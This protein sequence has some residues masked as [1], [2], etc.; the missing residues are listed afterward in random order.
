MRLFT[1]CLISVLLGSEIL[2]SA[3][4]TS[5]AVNFTD[6]GFN[7]FETV[8]GNW[9][10]TPTGFREYS[11]LPEDDSVVVSNRF[12]FGP[13]AVLTAT[14]LPADTIGLIWIDFGRS[15]NGNCLRLVHE[16]GSITKVSLFRV[17]NGKTVLLASVDNTDIPVDAGGNGRTLRFRVSSSSDAVQVQ[18]NNSNLFCIRCSEIPVGGIALGVRGRKVEFKTISVKR[19]PKLSL[20]MT[21]KEIKNKEFQVKHHALRHNF[22]R[23][24][25][26]IF[27]LRFINR[28]DSD[29]FVD[30]VYAVFPDGTKI[31]LP[32]KIAKSGKEASWDIPL[33]GAFWDGK[34][35]ITVEGN[36]GGEM[37]QTEYDVYFAERPGKDSYV[38]ATWE[39]SVE[40][41]FLDFLSKNGIN[42]STMVFTPY[43][44]FRENRKVVAKLNDTAV[45]NNMV[46][47]A[48]FPLI[49]VLS[50][51]QLKNAIILP[52]G[53]PGRLLNCNLPASYEYAGERGRALGKFLKDYPAFRTVLLSSEA[54]NFMSISFSPGDRERYSK[55]FGGPVPS[56]KAESADIDGTSGTILR[57]PADIKKS[58]SPIVPTDN[59]WYRWLTFLWKR[60]FGDNLL[61]AHLSNE[62][63]KENPDLETIH[64]PFRD[65]P[66]FDRNIGLD[67]YGTWF[68]PTPDAGESFMAIESILAAIKGGGGTQKM[69]FGASLWLYSGVF[70]PAR[71]QQAGVQPENIYMETLH[72]GLASRPDKFEVFTLRDLHPDTHLE[73]RQDTLL[74]KIRDFSKNMA[75]PLWPALRQFQRE[76]RPVSLLLSSASQIFG[77]QCW[78]GYGFSE[79]NALLNILWKANLPSNVVFEDTLR[80]DS[81]WEKCKILVLGTTTH[82]PEDVFRKISDFAGK[83]GKVLAC[84]PF[85]K[86]IPG[87]EPLDMN[88]DFAT[89]ASYHFLRGKGKYTALKA[90]EQRLAYANKL[91]ERYR[92]YI[93]TF[94][95]S[96]SREV[97]LRTLQD[98]HSKF[99]FALNDKRTEGDHM[100]K[101]FH[102]VL[103][104]GMEQSVSIQLDAPEGVVYEF[105]AGKELPAVRENKK[106]RLDL[107]FA[108]SEGKVLL[109]YPERI[110]TLSVS[111]PVVGKAGEFTTAAITLTDSR[112]E[113][114]RGMVP[115]RICWTDPS[116]RTGIEYNAVRNGKKKISKR[117]AKGRAGMWSVLVTELASGKTAKADFCQK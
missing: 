104:E 114:F 69:Q 73:Y 16:S 117:M 74:T 28:C 70:C 88:F 83:G 52:N 47:K 95:D 9:Q 66:V 22:Y 78:G 41:S 93:K 36:A 109:C 35:K 20:I 19:Y 61:N 38:F 1:L 107:K 44:D 106:L 111:S 87:A 86:L 3:E 4:H 42:G 80:K 71:S 23:D 112:G 8:S 115:V 6:G 68:Y 108:P 89:K 12:R 75:E 60:G 84:A 79:E 113:P 76:E 53:K 31:S 54:E 25:K 45:R 65:Y 48:S 62:I 26:P 37:L 33:D 90:Q 27:E 13:N 50:R 72:L 91:R 94:A 2:Q 81:E 40:P 96:D 5:Y 105:P 32:D 7:P 10:E 63:K 17:V 98:E 101:K 56:L 55:L 18:L 110:G 11:D 21:P 46:L 24:E 103:D 58:T 34:C 51:A 43:A 99:V 77:R 85:D 30:H 14:V 116:G 100:G 97:Y 39:G 29:I 15:E 82:L 64:D 67:Y 92:Q 59:I 57:V 102:A 49:L